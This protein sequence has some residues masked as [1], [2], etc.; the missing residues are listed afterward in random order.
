MPLK[1]QLKI[2]I[3]QLQNAQKIVKNHEENINKTLNSDDIKKFDK[4]V[5]DL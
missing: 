1:A 2:L 4:E 5:K 3:E